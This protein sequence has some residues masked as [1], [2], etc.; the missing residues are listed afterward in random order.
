MR[1]KLADI[2]EEKTNVRLNDRDIKIIGPVAYCA[3]E[4]GLKNM[5]FLKKEDV[6]RRLEE[7]LGKTTIKDI[8]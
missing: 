1:R 5:L 7:V 4:S 8:Q 3:V 2:I 6:L